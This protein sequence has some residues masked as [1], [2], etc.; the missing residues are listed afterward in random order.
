VRARA[1]TRTR[2]RACARAREGLRFAGLGFGLGSISHL[3]AI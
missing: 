1:C 3:E 2:V